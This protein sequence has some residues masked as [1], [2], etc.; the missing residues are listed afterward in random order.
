MVVIYGWL[1]VN[2][3]DES[4]NPL[5]EYKIDKVSTKLSGVTKINRSPAIPAQSVEY[6]DKEDVKKDRQD[7]W[8]GDNPLLIQLTRQLKRINKSC[9]KIAENIFKD[10]NYIDPQFELYSKPEDILLLMNRVF[11]E[12]LIHSESKKAFDLLKSDIDKA[13]NEGVAPQ[14]WD[15]VLRS[16]DVCRENEVFYFF[17]TMFES[18]RYDQLTK[19]DKKKVVKRFIEHLQNLLNQQQSMTNLLFITNLIIKGSKGLGAEEYLISEGK[20]IFDD[21][22]DFWRI[23]VHY[24]QEQNSDQKKKTKGI[25]FYRDYIRQT[26]YYNQ[27]LR[28]IIED[29]LI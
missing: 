16:I 6:F 14:T 26:E 22:I 2:G 9:E 25:D 12:M 20:R 21:L 5:A 24:Y 17:E 3:A 4:K 18:F 28:K 13:P 29:L 1:K 7:F 8:R 27:E 19:S 23:N 15:G 11:N 10:N